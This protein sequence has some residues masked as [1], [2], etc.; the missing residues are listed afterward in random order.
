MTT[1]IVLMNFQIVMKMAMDKIFTTA[2]KMI[3]RFCNFDIIFS[4]VVKMAMDK[5]F[6]TA[7]KM[8]SKLQNLLPKKMSSTQ[9]ILKQ[10]VI[11]EK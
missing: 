5:I 4:A 8:I 1:T 10:V 3:L 6:T 7:L 2:L 9:M 11:Q